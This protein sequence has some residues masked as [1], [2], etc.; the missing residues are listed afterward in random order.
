MIASIR[1]ILMTTSPDSVVVEVAGV[2]YRIVVP[3]PVIQALGS[4]GSVVQLPTYLQVRRD[5]RVVYGFASVAQ[6]AV[7]ERLISVT[8]VGP[9]LALAILSA[10]S[11]DQLQQAIAS[12]NSAVL[13]QVP[14][15]GNRIAA[16]LV[17][18]LHD[19]LPGGMDPTA[20]AAVVPRSAALDGELIEVLT[21]LGYSLGEAHAAVAAVPADAP[22]DLEARVRLA[23]RVLSGA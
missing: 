18:E 16:R 23:L 6:R 1:G 9:R 17:L 5:A 15:V 19:T 3:T 11:L 13:A 14:G 8:G 12:E 20:S 22:A 4:I 10:L 2:G 7:F 21:T